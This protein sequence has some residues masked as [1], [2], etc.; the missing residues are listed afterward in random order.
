[1]RGSLHK[2]PEIRL[3]AMDMCITA[4]LIA[5]TNH[6]S[7]LIIM[8]MIDKATA[9]AIRDAYV[10][11]GEDLAIIELWGFFTIDDDDAA[12][13]CVR[14]VASW[15]PFRPGQHARQYHFPTNSK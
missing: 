6:I 7:C 15:R 5:E 13:R 12:R 1:V 11:G 8:I 14:T 9:S 4:I 3:D 2:T 10:E